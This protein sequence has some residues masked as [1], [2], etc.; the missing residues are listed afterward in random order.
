MAHRFN[1]NRG[2]HHAMNPNGNV[3]FHRNVGVRKAHPNLRAYDQVDRCAEDGFKMGLDL[4][5]EAFGGVM[6]VETIIE[7]LVP[8]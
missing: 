1:L 8:E 2:F 5:D 6:S 7:E 4:I 3:D